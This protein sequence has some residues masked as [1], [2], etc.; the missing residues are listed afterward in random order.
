M[1]ESVSRMQTTFG[2]LGRLEAGFVGLLD[3]LGMLH[4]QLPGRPALKH[5]R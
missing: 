3:S 5:A 2:R 4:R 1:A